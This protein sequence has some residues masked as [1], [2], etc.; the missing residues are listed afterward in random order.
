MSIDFQYFTVEYAIEVHDNIVR[1]SG[2]FFGVRD[3]GLI[4]STI[5]HM[6]NDFYYPDIED[7]L[8]H[9]FYSINKNHCFN[10]GNKRASLALSV[11]FLYLNGLEVLAEKFILTMENIVV[12]VADN[13]IDR[14]LLFEIIQSIL[15]EEDFSEELKIKI[16]H[17][18]S[19]EDNS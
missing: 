14:D 6:K 13:R 2:G 3:R 17:A 10:D 9:L 5:E 18:K 4:E 8:T 7:K 19:E 12:D 1:E 16:I 11:Y 15:Y